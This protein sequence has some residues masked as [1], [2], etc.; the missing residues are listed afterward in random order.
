[1]APAPGGLAGANVFGRGVISNRRA[2]RRRTSL[3]PAGVRQNKAGARQG[4][5]RGHDPDE[6]LHGLLLVPRLGAASCGRSRYMPSL[7]EGSDGDGGAIPM[8]PL[9]NLLQP[10]RVSANPL[11][12]KNLE[13]LFAKSPDS[14]YSASF[15]QREGLTC[16]LCQIGLLSKLTCNSIILP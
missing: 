13:I 15:S 4:A 11:G 8:P 9:G 5:C 1:M 2:T 6:S 12:N 10:D 7:I 16:L 14:P 3:K